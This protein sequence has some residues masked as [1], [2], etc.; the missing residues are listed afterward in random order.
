MGFILRC[1]CRVL[2]PI[3]PLGL[4]LIGICCSGSVVH[5]E[6]ITAAAHVL[7]LD[8][9]WYLF[10]NATA[11]DSKKIKLTKWG[12]VSAHSLIRLKTPASDNYITVVGSNLEIILQQYCHK[13]SA[14]YQPIM[15]PETA[16]VPD[17]DT[18]LSSIV[19]RVLAF[20][21]KE[22]PL[23]SM[24]RTRG[25]SPQFAEGVVPVVDEKADLSEVMHDVEKGRYAL[26]PF[27]SK[28]AS[29]EGQTALTFE[30]DPE[31]QTAVRLG[32]WTPGL[33]EIGPLAS[34]DRM[35]NQ[36][37]SIRVLLCAE[38]QCFHAVSSFETV[39]ASTEK[40]NGATTPETI[41]QFLRAYLV[42]LVRSAS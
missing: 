33:Y 10:P 7:D 21:V 42:E 29:L 17:V 4:V 5:S 40:W 3:G 23:L 30:W 8:G 36:D 22:P 41:H 16:S 39:R 13:P 18:E 15:V 32:S 27:D 38:Q 12:A 14:C 26:T 2:R 11:Q 6:E 9:D 19:G 25:G 24:V 1:C 28:S 31:K 35:E 20:L 37:I 34:S